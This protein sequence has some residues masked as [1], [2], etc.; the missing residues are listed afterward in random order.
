MTQLRQRML[1]DMQIRNF[2]ENT[3]QSYLQQVSLFARHFRRSPEGLGPENR[4]E[5]RRLVYSH[6]HFGIAFL[7]RGDPEKAVGRR[8]CL[9]HAEEVP[10]ATDHPEPDGG[11]SVLELRTP[12]QVAHRADGLLRS[13][14]AHLGSD[15]TQAD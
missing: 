5:A 12:T 2:S 3:R 7:V 10:N 13:G 15:R 1:E 8:G 11:A 4:E 14:T 6:R 9:A